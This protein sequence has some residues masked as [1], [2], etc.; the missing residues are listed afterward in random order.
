[1]AKN[2]SSDFRIRQEAELVKTQKS[3]DMNLIASESDSHSLYTGDFRV[4]MTIQ[5]CDT[6]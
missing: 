1:M 5:S 2:V 4:F 3:C 6:N